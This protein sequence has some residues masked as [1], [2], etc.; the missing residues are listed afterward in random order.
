M[1]ASINKKAFI[2]VIASSQLDYQSRTGH[3]VR[4]RVLENGVKH[5]LRVNKSD[6]PI[7]RDD[8]GRGVRTLVTLHAACHGRIGG[9]ELIVR[10]RVAGVWPNSTL[11]GI[12][13]VRGK[14]DRSRI[15]S[16]GVTVVSGVW[17]RERSNEAA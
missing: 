13:G 1:I 14:R 6:R 8:N 9:F 4:F 2:S 7:V 11:L 17:V 12:R 3:T 15:L 5:G 10:L 16:G